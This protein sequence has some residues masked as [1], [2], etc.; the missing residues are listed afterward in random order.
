VQS[1]CE[2]I[3]YLTIVYIYFTAKTSEARRTGA[4]ESVDLIVTCAM[5]FTRVRSTLV[6][7]HSAVA[8]R[9]A[10]Q[11]LAKEGIYSVVTCCVVLTRMR[12]A[13]VNIKLALVTSIPGPTETLVST[14]KTIK[15]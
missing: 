8:S 15:N 6:N 10:W 14:C 11:T 1:K 2:D 3:L 9:E 5:V 13:F 4:Q 7:I 12:Q